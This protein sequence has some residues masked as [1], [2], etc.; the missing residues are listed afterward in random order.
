MHSYRLVP[1]DSSCIIGSVDYGVTFA[2]AV[3]TGNV[4]AVQFHPEKSS[5]MGLRMLAN[6]GRIVREQTS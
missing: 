4:F 3:Q 2:A 5:E 1:E 6:F